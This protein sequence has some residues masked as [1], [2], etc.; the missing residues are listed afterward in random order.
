MKVTNTRKRNNKDKNLVETQ[1]E[2]HVDLQDQ[3]G[4][5]MDIVLC[6]SI[7]LELYFLLIHCMYFSF[8]IIVFT[9]SWH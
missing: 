1:D 3:I 2:E 5:F 7:K 6:T 8:S 4:E 9:L